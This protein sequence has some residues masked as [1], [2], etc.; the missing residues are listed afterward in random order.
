MIER[1]EAERII[2]RRLDFKG[3]LYADLRIWCAVKAGL[4]PAITELLAKI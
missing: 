2:L 1:N 4:V 3:A